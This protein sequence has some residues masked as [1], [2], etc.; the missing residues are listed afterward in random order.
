MDR[1]TDVETPG[2]VTLHNVGLD[3]EVLLRYLCSSDKT[4]PIVNRELSAQELSQIYNSA[5]DCEHLRNYLREMNLLQERDFVERVQ[6]LDRMRRNPQ[7]INT[8]TACQ[9]ACFYLIL[10]ACTGGIFATFYFV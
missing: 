6:R 8:T 2:F 5:W 9:R 4:R 3:L 7:P 1:Y 10:F